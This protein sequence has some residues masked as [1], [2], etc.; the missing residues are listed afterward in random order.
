MYSTRKKLKI[1]GKKP[2]HRNSL[3]HSQILELIRVGRIKTTP[4]K[5]KLLKQRFDKLITEAKKQTPASRRQ[6]VQY[7][8]NDKA[9][10]RLYGKIL[11]LLSDSNSGYILSARTLPR[12][13]DNA[14]QTIYMIKGIELG[15]KKS[16]LSSAL[17]RQDSGSGKGRR[18]GSRKREDRSQASPG[19]S[20]KKIES[21][22]DT[23]RVSM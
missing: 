19:S 21:V 15:E 13:G 6:V 16:R 8:R 22:D 4:S 10:A 20:S 18:G 1:Q 23:R 7:L 3:V 9:E 17:D 5:G 12:K 2:S 11:P 14:P